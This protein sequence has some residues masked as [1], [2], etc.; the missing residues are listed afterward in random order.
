MTSNELKEILLY[1]IFSSTVEIPEYFL[2]LGTN[3]W[4]AD[5]SNK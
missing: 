1:A 3:S 4:P 5:E 2:Q